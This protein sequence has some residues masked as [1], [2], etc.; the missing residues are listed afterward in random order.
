METGVPEATPRA[1][2]PLAL[3]ASSRQWSVAP[4][5]SACEKWLA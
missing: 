3:S 2:E 1:S 4:V 5:M